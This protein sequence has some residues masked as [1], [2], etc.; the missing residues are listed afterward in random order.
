MFATGFFSFE[1]IRRSELSGMNLGLKL[2]ALGFQAGE[3]ISV[4]DA[5]GSERHLEIGGRAAH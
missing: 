3:V 2:A 1:A 5:S 4:A